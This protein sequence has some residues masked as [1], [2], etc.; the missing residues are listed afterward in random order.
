MTG[1]SPRPSSILKGILLLLTGL[2]AGCQERG[3]GLRI[4]V[5]PKGMTHEFWQSIHRGALRAAQ[6]LALEGE[7]VEVIF[8]GPLRER[9]MMEQIEI[10]DRRVA[11]HAD[12]LVLAP[13]H[14]QIMTAPV[15]RAKDAGVP[16]VVIDSG[17]ADRDLIVKYVATDNYNGG[18]MAAEH[19][20]ETLTAEGK[21]RPKLIL[22]RYAIG[23]ESTEKREQGFLDYFDP[24]K[25]NPKRPRKGPPP[26]VEWLDKD[27]Y[28]GATRDSAS[29]AAGPLVQQFGK[30]V[31]AIFAPNESSASGTLDVLR[32]QAL[33]LKGDGERKVH[34]MAFDS[35][36]PL[37]QAIE[38]GDVDGS[39]IQDPYFMGYLG[40]YTLVKSIRGHD[41]SR[42]GKE[43]D[44][45]TG[46]YLVARDNV[47]AVATLE[48]FDPAYQKARTM[49]K[50]EFPMVAG[51][52]GAS[53][54][55]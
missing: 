41:V 39:I 54:P 23:S 20:A 55:R 9:D 27:H 21:T 35:S 5:I 4:V 19:L 2:C 24:A 13:Q 8:D 32:S 50:P 49:P 14:S 17:L 15:R 37:L 36:K 3:P 40:V 46:E 7:S 22:L 30:Q 48:K 45:S 16:V 42:G 6:E 29:R 26:T 52:R 47:K 31:D 33:N 25:T 43:L 44:V 1:T 18:W 10:V 34:L 12:G 11:T 53:A 28:A 38:E 51:E